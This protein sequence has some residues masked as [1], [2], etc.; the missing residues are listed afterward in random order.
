LQL[1]IHRILMPCFCRVFHD[2][3][4]SMPCFF[5][6][7]AVIFY[8]PY[9]RAMSALEIKGLYIKRYIN[10]SVYFFTF[11][12]CDCQGRYNFNKLYFMF[13]VPLAAYTYYLQVSRFSIALYVFYNM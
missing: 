5:H 7:F 8:C 13:P 3:F 10:S 1:K 4:Q 11:L 12:L 6:F 2:F 9:T